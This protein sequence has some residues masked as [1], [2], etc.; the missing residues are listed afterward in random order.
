MKKIKVLVCDD[1]AVFREGVKGILGR[2]SD[3]EVVGEAGDGR[4]AV[5]LVRKLAP[6]IV[7]MDI[8][9]PLLKGFDATRS[10]KKDRPETRVLI[11]TVYDDDD[12]VTRCLE[13]GASGYLLKDAPLFQLTYAV[14]EVAKGQRYMSPRV[15][16]GM[17]SQALPALTN[18]A[19]RDHILTDREREVLVLLAE[20]E[21]LKDIA[22]QLHLSVKTVDTHKW[23]LMKKLD[24]HDRSQ[25]IRY[26]IRTKLIEA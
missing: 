21:S 2:E 13:A 25:L 19:P 7:L 16:K 6:D 4:E 17:I 26:A 18:E 11:L 10:I 14:R 8:S 20:G 3:I 23:K 24:I 1:H 12:L 9:L 22:R 15:L 5:Q